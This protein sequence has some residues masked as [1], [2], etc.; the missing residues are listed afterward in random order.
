MP[1]AVLDRRRK[2]QPSKPSEPRSIKHPPSSPNQAQ[3]TPPN[4]RDRKRKSDALDE[5]PSDWV[6]D[7]IVEECDDDRVSLTASKSLEE[8]SNLAFFYFVEKGD[9]KMLDTMVVA[10]K[11]IS[12][13]CNKTILE[14]ACPDSYDDIKEQWDGSLPYDKHPIIGPTFPRLEKYIWL[15]MAAFFKKEVIKYKRKIK[16]NLN[17]DAKIKESW[18]KMCRFLR[19]YRKLH[20]YLLLACPEKSREEIN[21]IVKQSFKKCNTE[22]QIKS[23]IVSITKK[24]HRISC[25]DWYTTEA[26]NGRKAAAQTPSDKDETPPPDEDET[27]SEDEEELR[28]EVAKNKE[29]NPVVVKEKEETKETK[30]NEGGNSVERDPANVEQAKQETKQVGNVGGFNSVD[31]N[32]MNTSIEQFTGKR[33]WRGRSKYPTRDGLH[34]GP[35]RLLGTTETA[36]LFEEP[37][38]TWKRRQIRI[39]TKLSSFMDMLSVSA[40]ADS[41]HFA[42]HMN[43]VTYIRSILCEKE[44]F[45]EDGKLRPFSITRNVCTLGRASPKQISFALSIVLFLCGTFPKNLNFL[46]DFLR[47]LQAQDLIFPAKLAGMETKCEVDKIL[48]ACG[49]GCAKDRS[50]TIEKIAEFCLAIVRDHAGN[51][52]MEMSELVALPYLTPAMA[53]ILLHDCFGCHCGLSLHKGNKAF[54]IATG[55]VQFEDSF[56][57]HPDGQDML[58]M[59][60]MDDIDDQL[61]KESLEMWLPPT[62]YPFINTKVSALQLLIAE[63]CSSFREEIEATLDENFNGSSIC[64]RV[65]NF[66]DMLDWMD[67]DD[68]SVPV[69][70]EPCVQDGRLQFHFEVQDENEPWQESW[71][72]FRG[73]LGAEQKEAPFL[74]R[75]DALVTELPC[76][77][78][79]NANFAESTS[80]KTNNDFVG[81]EILAQ[82]QLYLLPKA[83]RQLEDYNGFALLPGMITEAPSKAN[84]NCWVLEWTASPTEPTVTKEM[85]NMFIAPNKTVKAWLRTAVFFH[86][87]ERNKQKLTVEE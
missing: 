29:E 44:P 26:V 33:Y 48:H 75:T 78:R 28:N 22:G 74:G 66:I 59:V 60:V 79:E 34:G 68:W 49:M 36:Y 8:L 54:I 7:S 61:L 19:H 85:L 42:F 41:I 27:E 87:Q 65:Y 58:D 77:M 73:W 53:E 45:G 11:Y 20:L 16:K 76:L 4:P 32:D 64:N 55:L 46:F 71:L 31:A 84:G 86:E 40:V 47:R 70:S 13:V 39:L 82:A 6:D 62:L 25:P 14:V 3:V 51:I 18:G 52:P 72:H 1:R 12:S 50:Y 80:L 67:G 30:K 2:N 56:F 21:K 81:R 17:V 5:I 10:T 43:R 23:T 9:N 69:Y 35:P 38:Y 15:D 63:E 57:I 83:K 37:S 24:Y